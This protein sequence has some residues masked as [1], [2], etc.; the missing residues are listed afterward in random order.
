MNTPQMHVQAIEEAFILASVVEA[1]AWQRHRD[2]GGRVG[3]H[4]ATEK[5]SGSRL[6]VIL[7]N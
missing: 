7:H 6:I 4:V 1:H 3:A 5:G 2:H